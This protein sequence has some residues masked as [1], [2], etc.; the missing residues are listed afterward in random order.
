MTVSETAPSVQEIQERFEETALPLHDSI[1]R[2]N[3]RLTGDPVAAQDLTQETYLRAFRA[4]ASFQAG[5]NCRAW[6]LQIAHNVFCRDYRGRRRITYRTA[7]DEDVDVLAQFRADMPS[8]EEEALRQLDREA[9]RRALAKLPE[10]YRVALTL[11]ELQGLSCEEAAAVMGTPKGTVL[12][13]LH[14]GR[15]RLRRLLPAELG[16]ARVRTVRTP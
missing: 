4:F 1:Y 8:P 9:L 14:R 11:V 15:A 16:R 7:D 10:Q 2:A 3:L 6:M 12:S 13:R 5:T